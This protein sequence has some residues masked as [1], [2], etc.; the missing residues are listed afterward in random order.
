MTD[1]SAILAGLVASRLCHDFASPLGAMQNGLELFALTDSVESDSLEYQLVKD[2]C[3]YAIARLS[4]YRIAF[5][6]AFERQPI[7]AAALAKLCTDYAE[8]SRFNIS[9]FASG[10]FEHSSIQRMLL[11]LLCC[12]RAL[13]KG[14][15]ISVTY[16]A[17]RW[18]IM[19]SSDRILEMDELWSL[20][21]DDAETLNL[22]A[23]QVQF[24][25]LKTLCQTDKIP[26]GAEVTSNNITLKIG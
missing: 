12:E 3:D 8:G 26:A 17:P 16:T 19:A 14:G 18:Q 21:E 7:G 22:P 1:N 9:V 20:L 24:L 13:P 23:S 4:L 15:D 2:S 6:L 10:E 11:G 5:G 25:F